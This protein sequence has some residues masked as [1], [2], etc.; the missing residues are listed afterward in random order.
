[1]VL[2]TV[3]IVCFSFPLFTFALVPLAFFYRRVM[4]YALSFV[5]SIRY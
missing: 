2:G 4:K 5:F 3:A 1:M